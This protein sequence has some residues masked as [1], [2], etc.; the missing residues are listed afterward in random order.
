M[1]FENGCF[2]VWVKE[3]GACCGKPLVSTHEKGEEDDQDGCCNAL[4]SPTID[5]V[6]EPMSVELECHD[7]EPSIKSNMAGQNQINSNKAVGHMQYDGMNV[8]EKGAVMTEAR[9]IVLFGE[10]NTADTL[11]GVPG[12][13]IGEDMAA[14]F[15]RLYKQDAEMEFDPILQ[16]LISKD[17]QMP[18]P[19]LF[20]PMNFV[21]QNTY[22]LP[23]NRIVMH[24][25][26][27]S[28]PTVLCSP[29]P[30]SIKRPRGRQQPEH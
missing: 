22:T 7:E 9:E 4:G 28:N 23:L 3:C 11:H 13:M 10:Q 18:D 1:L 16:E 14:S 19:I 8:G 26:G 17:H 30:V 25:Y 20:D 12:S 6:S 2:E 15:V 29:V 24:D 27:L 21:E 5:Q